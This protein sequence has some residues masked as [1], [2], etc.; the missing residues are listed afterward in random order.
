MP[1]IDGQNVKEIKT[2]SQGIVDFPVADH[3][4]E[5]GSFIKTLIWKD[6]HNSGD[7]PPRD[8]TSFSSRIFD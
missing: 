3:W 4:S 5:E 8:K 7:K 6:L 1:N 2:Y